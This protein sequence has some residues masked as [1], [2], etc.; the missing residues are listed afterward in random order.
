MILVRV[1]VC[2]LSLV[3]RRVHCFGWRPDGPKTRVAGQM[4]YGMY[5][6]CS[7]GSTAVSRMRTQSM[8]VA[9]AAKTRETRIGADV[10][11]S[12]GRGGRGGAAAAALVPLGAPHLFLV[13]VI[14][15]ISAVERFKEGLCSPSTID[16]ET[17]RRAR[18]ARVGAQRDLDGERNKTLR[19][20]L[21]W[22]APVVTLSVVAS[23]WT[24]H[25]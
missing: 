24:A 7:G 3:S 8:G 4:S 16:R 15:A 5:G 6:P 12:G 20:S 19:S 23:G 10:T 17:R 25:I 1:V 22:S 21:L 2:E 14:S 9:E 13:T 18:G 11:S